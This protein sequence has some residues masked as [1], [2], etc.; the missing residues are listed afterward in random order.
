MGK[1]SAKEK[2]RR[3]SS[4]RC[5]LGLGFRLCSPLYCFAKCIT[6]RLER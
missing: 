4:V 1:G 5:F 3:D 2:V 6:R